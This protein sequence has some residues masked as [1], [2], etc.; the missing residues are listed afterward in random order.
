[1]VTCFV[2]R[3][4]HQF[5]AMLKN[6]VNLTM[7]LEVKGHPSLSLRHS[8]VEICLTLIGYCPV[9]RSKTEIHIQSHKLERIANPK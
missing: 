3:L 9:W 1:M 6:V 2:G 8:F 5:G 7:L 4:R